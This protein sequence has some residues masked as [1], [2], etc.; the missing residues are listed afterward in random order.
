MLLLAKA[1]NKL[2][3]SNQGLLTLADES[4]SNVTIHT[5]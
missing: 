5:L 2:I 4:L 3:K 1:R